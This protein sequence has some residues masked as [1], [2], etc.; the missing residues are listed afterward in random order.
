MGWCKPLSM[1]VHNSCS[2]N[3]GFHH[4]PPVPSCPL[5][6]TMLFSWGVGVSDTGERHVSRLWVSPVWHC[7]NLSWQ[8]PIPPAAVTCPPPPNPP[9]RKVRLDSRTG[10]IHGISPPTTQGWQPTL[11]HTGMNQQSAQVPGGFHGAWWS[12]S[13]DNASW[14]HTARPWWHCCHQ[15]LSGHTNSP[16]RLLRMSHLFWEA[17]SSPSQL[18]R[19]PLLAL[20]PALNTLSVSMGEPWGLGEI[21]LP[22]V[23]AA[24]K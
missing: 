5:L 11:P 7:T 3:V 15:H 8:L 23:Y 16:R 13:G 2:L 22:F 12:Q 18:G 24:Q 10:H 1:W 9:K 6:T 20:R 17:C 21:W 4:P 19:R 14:Q